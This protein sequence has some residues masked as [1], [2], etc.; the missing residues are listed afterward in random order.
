MPI[1][2]THHTDVLKFWDLFPYTSTC[3]AYMIQ[4]FGRWKQSYL[5]LSRA[6]NVQSLQPE[7]ALC[8]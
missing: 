1:A 7:I 5:L 2:L 3:M 8:N 4:D 6:V